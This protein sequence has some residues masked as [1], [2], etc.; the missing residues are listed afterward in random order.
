MAGFDALWQIGSS[1]LMN[2]FSGE[3]DPKTGGGAGGGTTIINQ[4]K[5][6]RTSLKK[7]SDR[8]KALL[9]L[10]GYKGKKSLMQRQ[11]EIRQTYD[12]RR[13]LSSKGA[14]GKA[15]TAA[16]VALERYKRMFAEAAGEAT[17]SSGAITKPSTPR[18]A[19]V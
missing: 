4:N 7:Q 10:G 13:G 11:R 14:K 15:L 2:Y 3:D 6:T 17:S 12:S 8:Q 19:R 16:E 9:E 5:D 18:S 1:L